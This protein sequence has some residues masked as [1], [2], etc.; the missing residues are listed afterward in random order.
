MA[1]VSS[2]ELWMEQ[3]V[4]RVATPGEEHRRG[5]QPLNLMT[6]FQRSPTEVSV[7]P[8]GKI[9]GDFWAHPR[10]LPVV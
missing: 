2:H 1:S 4:R 10:S 6:V 5:N 3:S 8:H 7:H 9:T